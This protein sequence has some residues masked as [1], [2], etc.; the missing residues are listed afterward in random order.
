MRFTVT[1][2]TPNRCARSTT[3]ASR[4]PGD[5][6]ATFAGRSHVPAG[7][8]YSRNPQSGPQTPYNPTNP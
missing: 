6:G 7:E 3:R 4:T 2:V 1:C 8:T 5:Q